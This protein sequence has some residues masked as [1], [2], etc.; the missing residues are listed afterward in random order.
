[1]LF[2]HDFI[3]HLAYCPVLNH[4]CDS[5]LLP[6]MKEFSFMG[7]IALLV[8]FVILILLVVLMALVLPL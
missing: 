3:I 7:C 5:V 6:I 1:M 8:D 2:A 4:N